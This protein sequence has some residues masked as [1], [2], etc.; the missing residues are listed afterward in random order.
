LTF[1]VSENTVVH[2]HGSPYARK[3]IR[4]E[5]HTH[6]SPYA[7]N[8]SIKNGDLWDGYNLT[9][10]TVYQLAN[11]KSKCNTIAEKEWMIRTS[12]SAIRSWH[13]KWQRWLTLE[14]RYQI[15]VLLKEDLTHSAIAQATNAIESVNSV[16]R[17]AT[18][19]YKV[20]PDD[21]RA[22]KVIY[23]AIQ[24]ASKK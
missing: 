19:N 17:K 7:R 8:G 4:T 12:I 16:V 9:R 20:F 22:R 6:G 23:L 2:T 13:N 14:Q 24:Q 5:V 11:S 10:I 21:G 15:Y 1:G 3:S 18:R